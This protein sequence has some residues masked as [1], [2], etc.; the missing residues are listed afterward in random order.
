MREMM[1]GLIGG[2]LVVVNLAAFVIYGIDKQKAKRKK[3]RIPEATLL[4]IAVIGGS[5]GALPGMYTFHHKTRKI[6]FSAGVP[7]ILLIQFVLL[8]KILNG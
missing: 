1:T 3:W 5:V 7:V 8:Y 4:G 2:Y 6:K